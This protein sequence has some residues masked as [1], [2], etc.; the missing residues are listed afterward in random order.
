MEIIWTKRAITHLEDIH[1]FYEEKSL[2]TANRIYNSLLD[3]VEPLKD[4]PQLAQKVSVSKNIKR[5]YRSLVVKRTFKIIY[6]INQ[7]RIL[8]VAI[9]DCRQ[10][11]ETNKKKIQ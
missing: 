3:S 5:E 8:I 11:P 9:L 7:G 6:Y 4:F 1:K 10:G 2:I